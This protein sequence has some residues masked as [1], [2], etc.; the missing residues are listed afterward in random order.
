[1]NLKESMMPEYSLIDELLGEVCA[2]ADAD[3]VRR[4]GPAP[5]GKSE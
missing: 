5:T 3:R 1:V 4:C 2:H